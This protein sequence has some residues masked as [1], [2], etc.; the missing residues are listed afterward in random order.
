MAGV[1]NG[2]AARAGEAGRGFAVVAE[3]IRKLADQSADA[4]G[5]INKL[6]DG[7]NES[8]RGSVEDAKKASGIVNE[9]TGLVKDSIDVFQKMASSIDRLSQKVGD[10]N[11]TII[12]VDSRR[13]E[14]VDAVRNISDIIDRNG[15]N[16]QTVINAAEELKA[17][18]DNLDV[19]ADRLGDS[20]SELK[21]EVSG[22]K[23]V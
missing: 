19:T 7:I 5:E 9:Q 22:F 17:N 18:V 12:S 8:T 20:M 10:I 21:G 11:N 4:A 6:I 15:D 23:I 1:K 3:E 14:A 16:V 2:K 13:Q